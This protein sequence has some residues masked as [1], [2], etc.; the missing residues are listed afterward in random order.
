[1]RNRNEDDVEV[2]FDDNLYRSRRRHSQQDRRRY[3]EDMSQPDDD[4]VLGM[5]TRTLDLVKKLLIIAG[6]IAIV[7]MV[8]SVICSMAHILIPLL[9]VGAVVHFSLRNRSGRHR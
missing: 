7:M 4:K 8:I 9:L 1:M 2:G 6:G 3:D 5:D